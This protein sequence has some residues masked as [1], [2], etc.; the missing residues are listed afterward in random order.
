MTALPPVSAM[1]DVLA[2]WGH[3]GWLTPPLTT[4]VA[5]TVV[6]AGRARTVRLVAGDEGPGFMP[7]YELLSSDLRGDVVVVADAHLAPGAVWGEILALAAANA[8]ATAVLVDGAV[9]DVDDMR[10]IGV[11]VYAAALQVVGPA[12][13]A[14]VVAIDDP[15]TL[16]SVVVAAGD[17]VVADASGCLRIGSDAYGDVLDAARRYADGESQVVAAL[18]A[19]EPLTS[20]YIHKSQVVKEL[21]R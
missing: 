14:H 19:G 10:S 15:V 5:P 13:K 1:A 9:R 3:D 2:L 20:A 12:G 16:G 21:R 11:P 4:V 6:C 18:R 8:G 17:V 7:L